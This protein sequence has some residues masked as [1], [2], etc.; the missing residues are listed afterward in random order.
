MLLT[1]SFAISGWFRIVNQ[2]LYRFLR[3]QPREDRF[4]V[5]V[6]E[7]SIEHPGHDAVQGTRA[8][9]PSA[10]H[11]QEEL[12]V[13]V[14]NPAWIGSDIRTEYFLSCRAVNQVP[15]G[16]KASVDCRPFMVPIG[17]ASRTIAYELQKLSAFFRCRKY[18]GWSRLGDWF[19]H[20]IK[21]KFLLEAQASLRQWIPDR[22]NAPQI[23]DRG[24]DVL[25]G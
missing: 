8:H 21:P 13:I 25:I 23:D 14:R 5:F 19:R 3:A 22:R 9:L 2:M 7:V 6:A 1:A 11:R 12:F 15:A 10:H 16:K 24:C 4:Q 18:L 17:V 20:D